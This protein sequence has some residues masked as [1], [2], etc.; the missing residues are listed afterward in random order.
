MSLPSPAVPLLL[1]AQL[2]KHSIS[3][4]I[5]ALDAICPS[6]GSERH[7][8]KIQGAVPELA[9]LAIVAFPCSELLTPVKRGRTQPISFLQLVPCRVELKPEDNAGMGTAAC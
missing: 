1:P 5:F 3:T 6:H 8:K 4:A 2:G 7:K 9:L